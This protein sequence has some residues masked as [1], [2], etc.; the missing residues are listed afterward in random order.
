MKRALIAAVV[1][2]LMATPALAQTYKRSGSS[3]PQW[4]VE[5]IS[6]KERV[7][8]PSCTL[9]FNEKN[10]SFHAVKDTVDKD[11]FIYITWLEWD[12]DLGDV[13][14]MNKVS[15]AFWKNGKIA[16]SGSLNYETKGPNTIAIWNLG[17]MFFVDLAQ[18]DEIEFVMPGNIRRLYVNLKSIGSLYK[19]WA[20]C[21]EK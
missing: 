3:T 11:F 2:V 15:V 12:L 14:K 18:N 5:Y 4:K 13:G 16:Q 10:G 20:L 7:T 17:A 19:Q 1:A 21:G 9:G 6:D 8:N